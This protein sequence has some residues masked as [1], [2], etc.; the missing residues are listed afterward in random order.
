VHHATATALGESTSC[1]LNTVH[2]VPCW[3]YGTNGERGD[4]T[5]ITTATHPSAVSGLGNVTKLGFGEFQGCAVVASGG[6]L[7][8]GAN[9]HG[10]IGNG[11]TSNALTPAAVA[12]L[13]DVVDVGGGMFH[14]LALLKNGT[15]KAWGYNINGQLG[16]GTTTD[17]STPVTV[18]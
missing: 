3:G 12:G 10:E 5:T 6:E 7:C 17:S 13:A 1:V 2:N 15:T 8:W 14:S 11:S 9:L 18:S 16:D 4:G